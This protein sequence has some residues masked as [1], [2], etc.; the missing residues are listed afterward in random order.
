MYESLAKLQHIDRRWVYLAVA[1][2]CTIPFLVRISLPVY[3]SDETRGIYNAIESCPPDKVV[4]VDSEMDP[5]SVSENRGQLQAVIE[6]LFTRGVPF[7]AFSIDLPQGP[8]LVD[9]VISDLTTDHIEAGKLVR[10]KF[11][12]KRYGVDWVNLGYTVGGWQARQQIA[13]DVRKLFKQDSVRHYKLDDAEHLPIMQRFR[14]IDDV[15][16]IFNV[17][18]G[19]SEDWISFVHG[20][21]G[22]PIAFASAGINTTVYYRYLSSGQLCGLLVGVRGGAEYDALLHPKGTDGTNMGTRL[23]VPLA[24]G[25]V[26]FL[27]AI[28]LGNIGY[29][30]SR[31]MGGR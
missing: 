14:S 8:Q 17:G 27:V 10:A 7:V 28:G 9:G 29:F 22:T 23:I 18:Y 2:A 16:L 13:K 21:Y 6:H 20:V 11:P 30:A 31:R 5:G 19:A 15:H 24:F 4:L 25:H 26:V 12:N 3:I 1:L